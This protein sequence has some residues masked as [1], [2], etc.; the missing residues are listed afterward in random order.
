M[1]KKSQ[2]PITQWIA[3]LALA[4]KN[5][6]EHP[7]AFFELPGGLQISSNKVMRLSERE[8]REIK[9]AYD[10]GLTRI[11]SGS[12]FR[13]TRKVVHL[14]WAGPNPPASDES[15]IS[16]ETKDDLWTANNIF[17][18]IPP[19][20]V[21]EKIIDGEGE[22][23]KIRERILWSSPED[24]TEEALH[25]AA[26]AEAKRVSRNIMPK[27]IESASRWL[28]NFL[29]E[30]QRVSTYQPGVFLFT[31]EAIH[32]SLKDGKI[33]KPYSLHNH[34]LGWGLSQKLAHNI[35]IC[36]HLPHQDRMAIWSQAETDDK[37]ASRRTFAEI[38]KREVDGYMQKYGLSR[39]VIEDVLERC[40]RIEL[41]VNW[42]KHEFD[43][44]Q[45]TKQNAHRLR[46]LLVRLL[47]R[48]DISI[49]AR[50]RMEEML[51]MVNVSP[52]HIHATTV[53]GNLEFFDILQGALVI[54]K[55]DEAFEMILG[56]K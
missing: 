49:F 41:I 7:Y 11:L 51:S 48:M 42:L 37:E 4:T 33:L 9:L 14:E 25:I 40:S 6:T 32:D 47:D 10:G 26:T 15:E 30:C 17:I 45:N 13:S 18:F 5:A 22:H 28:Y 50:E 39:Y 21:Y 16:I 29:C 23:R 44:P 36:S 8:P 52:P 19:F 38:T 54:L 27:D 53:D 43:V 20:V 1:I 2:Y 55:D 12:R 24:F 56:L 46:R 34:V 35:E 31:M 3:M